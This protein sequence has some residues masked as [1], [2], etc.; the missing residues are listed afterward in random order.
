MEKSRIAD[1]YSSQTETYQKGGNII[2]GKV[3][4]GKNVGM[5]LNIPC[6]EFSEDTSIGVPT[7][8]GVT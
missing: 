5:P 7:S 4:N 6:I 3:E 8:L 2:V 1:A